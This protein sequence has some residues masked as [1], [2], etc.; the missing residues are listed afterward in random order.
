MHAN[1][2]IVV[3]VGQLSEKG[4]ELDAMREPLKLVQDAARLAL[5]DTNCAGPAQ[6]W[7]LPRR[8]DC[9]QHSSS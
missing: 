2:P 3:G 1:L 4:D 7:G 6:P 5:A 8:L 9:D